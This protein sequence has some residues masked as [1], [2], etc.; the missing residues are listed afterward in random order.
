MR[1]SSITVLLWLAIL[2]KLTGFFYC[3]HLMSEAN[4]SYTYLG[5]DHPQTWNI[6]T[7]RAVKMRFEDSVHFNIGSGQGGDRIWEAH[8]PG[9]GTIYLGNYK[10]PFSIAMIH[11][12]RCL[13]HLR[14]EL[15]QAQSLRGNNATFT[16]GKLSRH[17]L[18]YL[19]QMALCRAD[20]D[21]EPISILPPSL[22]IYEYRCN[23]WTVVY[24]AMEKN[25]KENKGVL[26]PSPF[27]V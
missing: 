23:D 10:Q 17:C 8:F 11:E 21:L 1:P 9:N 4:N 27:D 24:D 26:L 19:R 7:G 20:T 12:L 6:R 3:R 15:I 18:N 14:S 25:Q 16:L 22:H 5:D 2:L 13:A